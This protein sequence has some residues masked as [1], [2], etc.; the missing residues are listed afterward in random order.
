VKLGLWHDSSGSPTNGNGNGRRSAPIVPKQSIAGNALVAVVAIM[1]FLAALTTGAVSLVMAS[2]SAWQSDIARE[3][4]IQVRPAD[5]RDLEAD[6]AAATRIARAATGVAEVRPY[7]AVESARLLEP[8]LGSGI[9]LDDLPVPRLIAL[10]LARDGTPDL[11]ALRSALTTQVP[12]AS[13]DDHR[14]FIERMRAMAGAA[15]AAGLTVLA[16]VL[17]ATILS[18]AFATRGAMATNRHVVEVLHLIGAKDAFIASEF[19]G[20]FLILGLR[21]GAI[22]GG[23]AVVLLGLASLLGS[24]SSATA[25]GAQT[26]ALFGSYAIGWGSYGAVLGQVVLVAAV[27]ALTSRLVVQHTLAEYQ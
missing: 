7:T 11:A 23:A 4:T 27:A 12:T 14:G 17:T 13:V 10:T 19:Q 16:L 5:G 6:V 3:L 21:G 9:G 15:I 8:W 18:V 22:G 26:A 24:W 20:H 1:T 2:A 25:A